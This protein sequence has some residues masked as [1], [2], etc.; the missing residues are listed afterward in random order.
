[1]QRRAAAAGASEALLFLAAGGSSTATAAVAAA[2][3]TAL[4]EGEPAPARAVCAGGGPALLAQLLPSCGDAAA[5]AA[6]ALAALAAVDADAA[7][8]APALLPQLLRCAGAPPESS[9]S[10]TR[11]AVAA[12]AAAARMLAA[13]PEHADGLAAAE[14]ATNI[15]AALQRCSAVVRPAAPPAACVWQLAVSGPSPSASPRT[16]SIPALHSL[17]SL[18]QA[19][20]PDTDLLVELKL[21]PA[22]FASAQHSHDGADA[23]HVSSCTRSGSAAGSAGAASAA[24]SNANPDSK[25]TAASPSVHGHP[26]P[27]K[28]G[29]P[30]SKGATAVGTESGGVQSVAA[31]AARKAA[32]TV[33]LRVG[34][35]N[36]A[37]AALEQGWLEVAELAA[38]AC[39]ASPAVQAALRDNGAAEAVVRSPRHL[40]CCV[41]GDVCLL[42]SDIVGGIPVIDTRIRGVPG[43]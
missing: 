34:D 13:W 38:A 12:A 17:G 28:A 27:T 43:S 42:V 22:D 19:D 21:V 41:M 7:A 35:A 15:A 24:T 25:P 32:P 23:S 18:Y 3:L 33:A 2:A 16:A 9:P 4:C 37:A 1:M 20:S 29:D 8:H 6:A 5:E 40:S 36:D 39:E 30:A 14:A 26:S 10:R 31:A 11:C